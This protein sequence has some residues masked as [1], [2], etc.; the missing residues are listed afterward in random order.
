MNRRSPGGDEPVREGRQQPSY[1]D[2]AG[3]TPRRLVDESEVRQSEARKAAMLES[4]MDA[5]VAIDH[6][7]VITEFNPSAERVFGYRRAEV[8]GRPMADLLVPPSIR[9]RHRRAFARY[10][11]TEE[12]TILGRPIEITAMRADGSEFPVEL[13][14]TRIDLPGP[15]SF[16]AYIRDIGDRKRRE[17]ALQDS[18][19]RRRRL[20]ALLVHAQESERK[21]LAWDLHDDSIQVMT[22]VGLRLKSFRRRVADDSDL[23]PHFDD[24]EEVVGQAIRRLRALLFELRP[25]VL[26]R[27][28]LAAALRQYL[29]S[30]E[31]EGL[32]TT[33]GVRLR[34]E[35]PPE[36]RTLLYRLAQEALTNVRKHAR[37]EKVEVRLEERGDGVALRIRDDGAGFSLGGRPGQPGHLGLVAMQERAEV[38]GGWFRIESAPGAGTTVEVWVPLQP[39]LP[40]S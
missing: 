22:A 39:S 16:T 7:G 25:V 34:V 4:A 29:D 19:D 17:Q 24:L 6:Q 9:K 11:A 37:A 10:L 26:D 8:I 27:E 38:F 21:R 15:P 13:A 32:S 2:L 23:A 18:L 3:E 1:I 30:M 35:P 28:G 33:L 20:E 14:V 31:L 5:V 12:S 40:G 36:T